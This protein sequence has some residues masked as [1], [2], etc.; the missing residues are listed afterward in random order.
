MEKWGKERHPPHPATIQHFFLHCVLLAVCGGGCLV[1][2]LGGW[3]L[4]LR[5]I[6]FS[7][8]SSSTIISIQS[9]TVGVLFPDIEQAHTTNE[10]EYDDD[11]TPFSECMG[12]VTSFST[13]VST[14]FYGVHVYD[15]RIVFFMHFQSGGGGAGGQQQSQQQQSSSMGDGAMEFHQ[16]SEEISKIKASLMDQGWA[17]IYFQ[18]TEN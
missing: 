1:V 10:D 2:F 17:K 8:S 6:L 18:K 11:D 4:L 7:S 13:A 14:D 12:S 15:L 16:S 3:M 9:A 5:L